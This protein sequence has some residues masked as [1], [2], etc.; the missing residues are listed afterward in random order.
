LPEAL[1]SGT[2]F[3]LINEVDG[4]DEQHDF[5]NSDAQTMLNKHIFNIVDVIQFIEKDYDQIKV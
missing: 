5:E 3:T 1:D 4:E 2:I